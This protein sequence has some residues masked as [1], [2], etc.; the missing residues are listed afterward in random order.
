MAWGLGL[1]LGTVVVRTQVL[2]TLVQVLAP[3]CTLEALGIQRTLDTRGIGM[4]PGILRVPGTAKV[5]D[6][7]MVLG[8][9]TALGIPRAPG[10]LTG[11]GSG[12]GLQLVPAPRSY[13]LPEHLRNRRWCNIH[14]EEGKSSPFELLDL[15]GI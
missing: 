2:C 1:S 14:Q 5:P 12:L 11:S 13:L 15:V 3:L 7:Q 10:N 8:T 4:A 9:V 6:I